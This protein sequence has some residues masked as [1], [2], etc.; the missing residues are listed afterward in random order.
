MKLLKNQSG[1]AILELALIVA[2]LA[3]VGY[4]AYDAYNA[5]QTATKTEAPATVKQSNGVNDVPAAPE[6][7]ST[8]DLTAAEKTLDQ[9]DPEAN[10][11]DSAQLDSQL[12]AF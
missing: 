5:K 10:A 8:E 2:V 12:S 1:F 3:V 11:T 7:N 4:V 6:V 9:I